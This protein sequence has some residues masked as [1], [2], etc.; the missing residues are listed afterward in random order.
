MLVPTAALMEKENLPQ[1][2]F[3]TEQDA[4][5]GALE[6]QL[7]DVQIIDVRTAL[8]ARKTQRTQMKLCILKPIIIGQRRGRG[9]V[10]KR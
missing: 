3:N 9:L 10:M 2:A 4:L 5:I 8:Q 6:S 1:G 7:A